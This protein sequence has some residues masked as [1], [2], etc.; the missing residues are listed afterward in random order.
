MSAPETVPGRFLTTNRAATAWQR[1]RMR[2]ARSRATRA[3]A[4]SAPADTLGAPTTGVVTSLHPG[5]LLGAQP[6]ELVD[7]WLRELDA[8]GRSEKTLSGHRWHLIGHLRYVGLRPR[9]DRG[10]AGPDRPDPRRP[11]RPPGILPARPR[12]AVHHQPGW[13]GHVALGLHDRPPDRVA[14]HV[15]RLGRPPGAPAVRPGRRTGPGQRSANTC[16]VRSTSPTGP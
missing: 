15:L 10:R 5:V 2:P 13:R 1:A 14:A 4:G 16:R 9:G 6:A 8:A 3:A 11:G 7:A 12:P